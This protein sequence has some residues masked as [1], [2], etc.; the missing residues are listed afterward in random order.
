VISGLEKKR[1]VALTE[2]LKLA[3]KNIFAVN[4]IEAMDFLNCYM[5]LLNAGIFIT[6][7]NRED[8]YFEIIEAA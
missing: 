7:Q 6:D 4:V 1:N 5:K 8:K 2:I 3:N